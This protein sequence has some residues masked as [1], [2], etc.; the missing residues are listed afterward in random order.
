MN[1]DQVKGAAEN[2]GGKV[3]E[4]WGKI[5]GNPNTQAKGKFDQAK[6]QA[7]EDLGKLKEGV[8]DNKKKEIS[9]EAA[10]IIGALLRCVFTT[11]FLWTS[12]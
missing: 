9:S 7:R 11:S 1:R 5:T 4:E 12:V 6:G 10:Y 3:K 2:A 8:Q